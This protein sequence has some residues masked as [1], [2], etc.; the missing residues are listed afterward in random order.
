MLSQLAK[1]TTSGR[2]RSGWLPPVASAFAVGAFALVLTQI[3]NASG[4]ALGDGEQ[5]VSPRSASA[6]ELGTMPAGKEPAGD[7]VNVLYEGN[8]RRVVQYETTDGTP[9]LANLH[10]LTGSGPV[11][12]ERS[13]VFYNGGVTSSDNP[14][15]VI[16]GFV[17][18]DARGVELRHGGSGSGLE[19]TAVGAR[20]RKYFVATVKGGD[21]YEVR[22]TGA[23][24]RPMKPH[25]AE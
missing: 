8:G 19:A 3:P 13:E 16:A 6:S 17:P 2:L 20:G 23:D 14:V 18:R 22:A 25:M 21:A 1:G 7:V 10:I 5:R 15:T 11:V 24:G 9:C 4:S 12:C